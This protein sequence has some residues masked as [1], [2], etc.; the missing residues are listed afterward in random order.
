[1]GS[2]VSCPASDPGSHPAA[3]DYDIYVNFEQA[4]PLADGWL[5]L[6]ALLGVIGL[7]KKREWGILFM[8]LAG[9][10]AIFLGLMDLLYDL[11]H[12]MFTPLTAEAGTELAIVILL[13]V[14]G[15]VVILL[16]WRNRKL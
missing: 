9:S 15:P 3:A 13:L 11:E 7:C 4:F 5:V 1:L 2:L 12:A 10:A 6:A 8:L 16:A 14:L